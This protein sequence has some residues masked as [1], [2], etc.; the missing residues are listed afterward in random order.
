MP[1]P[2]NGITPEDIR[3]FMPPYRLSPDLLARTF[4][5]LPAPPPDATEAQRHV[6]VRRLIGE[7][8][9]HMPANATQARIAAEILI[10][11]EALNDTHGR[12]NA[13]G[14][15]IVEVC[16]LRR[17]AAAL[18]H[19]GGL[20]ERVLARHQQK[21][22]PFFGDVVADEVDIAAVDVAWC[23]VSPDFAGAD[24]RASAGA[25]SR[26]SAGA[27]SRA[28]DGTGSRASAGME[29]RASARAGGAQPHATP[30]AAASEPAASEPGAPEPRAPDAAASGPGAPEAAALESG[31]LER[32]TGGPCPQAIV[33]SVGPVELPLGGKE[34]ANVISAVAT[35]A[36]LT[37]AA[38]AKAA[39]AEAVATKAVATEV[40]ATEVAPA[41]VRAT[42][43][44]PAEV[45][46][47]EMAPAE[48]VATKV[49][50]TE[51]APAKVR[52][53]EVAPAEV[54]P[55]EVRA[56]EVPATEVP[57]AEVR[58]TEA[59]AAEVAVTE[60]A[61]AGGAP[62]TPIGDDEPDSVP[63]GA[64]DL[65]GRK[66]GVQTEAAPAPEVN[67]QNA[68]SPGASVVT[69]LDQGPGW[70][71]DVV[72]PR[73]GGPQELAREAEPIGS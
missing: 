24:S 62:S 43:M 28:S 55:A 13:P 22:V 14:L 46:A 23:S 5:A 53:T 31:A 9:G 26:A 47:T 4:R 33:Q 59:P 49:V 73:A 30:D 42:E 52:A 57:P 48:T 67:W 6:H 7:L 61:P 17:T 11:R 19:A 8:T 65:T 21:P 41:E 10:V 45:R 37:D 34:P 35:E 44:A 3:D 12:A 39:P 1:P 15:T 60:A 29:S 40:P 71:L 27:G 66:T 69:R 72:R 16:R 70:T 18:T 58:A 68:G 64:G 36:A 54:A 50:A 2:S 63:A 56:T 32:A 51:V 38:P 25:G 20:L